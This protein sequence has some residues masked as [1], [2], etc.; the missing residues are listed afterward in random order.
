MNTPES[1]YRYLKKVGPLYFFA[2]IGEHPEV[3]HLL[4]DA[5]AIDKAQTVPTLEKVA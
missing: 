2:W 5:L 3:A 1:L 4:D